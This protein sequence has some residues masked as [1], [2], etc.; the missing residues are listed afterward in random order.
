VTQNTVRENADPYFGGESPRTSTSLWGPG[1]STLRS[2]AFG[3]R[4]ETDGGTIDNFLEAID[5][6]PDDSV[7]TGFYAAGY[8]DV[9]IEAREVPEPGL[10]LLGAGLGAVLIRRLRDRRAEDAPARRTSATGYFRAARYFTSA[11]ICSAVR[12]L[13]NAGML[14]PGSTSSGAVIQSFSHLASR[15]RPAWVRSGAP[16]LPSPSIM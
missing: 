3:I 6:S 4:P 11:S 16:G 2:R 5:G 9:N 10:A 13:P 12:K 7:R 1:A 8:A 14:A 15:S